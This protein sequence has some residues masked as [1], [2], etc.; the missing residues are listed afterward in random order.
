MSVSRRASAGSTS[1]RSGTRSG[2]TL[3]NRSSPSTRSVSILTARRLVLRRAL[4]GH[5]YALSEAPGVGQ[6]AHRVTVEVAQAL[7]ADRPLPGG[8]L[9][10]DV[11]RPQRTM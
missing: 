5:V 3:R 8:H 7:Q 2:G 10:R 11:L 6:Q 4:A 1:S 9:P